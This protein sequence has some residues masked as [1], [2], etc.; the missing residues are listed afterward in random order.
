MGWGLG[1][2]ERL[3]GNLGVWGL[4][5]LG[6]VWTALALQ[7]LTKTAA[8]TGCRVRQTA[9]MGSHTLRD[10]KTLP[11]D[12]R[13]R[14]PC[15]IRRLVRSRPSVCG[16]REARNPQARVGFTAGSGSQGPCGARP[17]PALPRPG[18][19]ALRP[20]EGATRPAWSPAGTCAA[21]PR[22]AQLVSMPTWA[23]PDAAAQTRHPGRTGLGRSAGEGDPG[24]HPLCVFW[25]TA[26]VQA[27]QADSQAGGPRGR[28][29]QRPP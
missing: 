20:A 8:G 18:G 5:G 28:K 19:G 4:S 29:D 1:T 12:S 25:A 22:L 16:C 6:H 11:R 9:V 17:V 15:G 10:P 7:C 23:L 2:T 27:E 24:T 13:P 3:Q 14:S 26:E 21:V